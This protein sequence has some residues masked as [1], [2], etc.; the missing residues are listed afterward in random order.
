MKLEEIKCDKCGIK[1]ESP[2]TNNQFSEEESSDTNNQN[3]RQQ[4]ATEDH[5]IDLNKLA[6]AKC[7]ECD[8][9][10]CT[11]CLLEHQLVSDNLNHKLIN[12]NF[13]GSLVNQ[14]QI[15]VSN[16]PLNSSL[17]FLKE[18]NSTQGA[19]TSLN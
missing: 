17:M 15:D 11:N 12:I 4:Q 8:Q 3:H 1:T 6:I 10:M 18:L 13:A 9:N 16:H 2:T 7:L 19:N 5:Q 14:H